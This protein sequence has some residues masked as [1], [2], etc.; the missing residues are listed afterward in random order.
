MTVIFICFAGQQP[1][2]E[3]GGF[4]ILWVRLYLLLNFIALCFLLLQIFFDSF[5]VIEIVSD[6]RVNISQLKRGKFLGDLFGGCAELIMMH[7]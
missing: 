1:R 7:Y 3:S 2:A 5:L 4:L 6:G